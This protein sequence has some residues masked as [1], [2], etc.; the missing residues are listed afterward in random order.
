MKKNSNTPKKEKSIKIVEKFKWLYEKAGVDYDM[1]MLILEHKLMMDKRRNPSI[2]NG[3]MNTT[4]NDGNRFKS[5]LLLYGVLGLFIAPVVVLNFNIM[6]QMT[7]FFGIFMFLIGTSFIADFA[8]VL[9]DVK[10]KNLLG[11]TGVSSKTI[12]AAKLTNILIYMT[13]ISIYFSLPSLFLSLR[14]GIFFALVF[15]IEIILI[16]IFM[17]L[18]TC[19][20]YYLILKFFDGEKLK[21]VINGIQIVLSVGIM[22]IYQVIGRVFGSLEGVSSGFSVTRWFQ[23]IL[24][25]LWFGAPLQIIG[26]GEVNISLITLSVLAII[27][28][29]ISI[30]IYFKIAKKFEENIQKLNDNS[31]RG[32]D[33]TPLSFRVGNVLCRNNCERSFFNFTINIIKS[34]RNFKLKTY[35]SLAMGFIF[36]FIFLLIDISDFNSF[37]AWKEMLPNTKL[38]YTIYMSVFCLAPIVMMVKYSDQCKAAWI[39]KAVPI[40]D[41]ASIFKG[42]TKAIIYKMVCPIY[43]LLSLIYVWLFGFKVILNLIAI[44]LVAIALSLISVKAMDKH[45]PFSV[46]FKDGE[47]MDDLGNTFLIILLSGIF[48]GFQL[49]MDVY[50]NYGVYYFIGLMIILI[51]L[52]WYRICKGSYNKIK[53]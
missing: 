24:P 30:G 40:E 6:F 45:F 43:I 10:D 13:S 14:H 34:E 17:I 49:A 37:W 42:V 25:P 15:L 20:I 1:M 51:G 52:L 23:W 33:K 46:S 53:F 47:K 2:M 26:S 28:P 36:P 18:V 11:V 5:A 16:N 38:Y 50:I 21:D 44:F 9:L 39:Y 31:Y 32:K 48:F 29:L 4:K 7:M 41:M 35:P 27:I 12:N 22:I 3:N 8:F 19:F